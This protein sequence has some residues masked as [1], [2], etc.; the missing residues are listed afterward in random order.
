MRAYIIIGR[1][2]RN[3]LDNVSHRAYFM[4]YV[5]TTGVIIYWNPDQ[6]FYIQKDH[7]AWFDEYNYLIYPED[8]HTPGSLLLQQDPEINLHN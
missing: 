3:N 1:V 7:H 2:T 8:K 4:G 6:N 5:S